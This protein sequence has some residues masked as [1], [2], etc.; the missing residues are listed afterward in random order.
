[1]KFAMVLIAILGM[2]LA[3]LFVFAYAVPQIKS[4]GISEYALYPAPTESEVMGMYVNEAD[5]Y[6]FISTITGVKKFQAKIDSFSKE[7]KLLTLNNET[8][9]A[10]YSSP[11]SHYGSEFESRPIVWGF[12][13]IAPSQPGN[14]EVKLCF[15]VSNWVF[16]R[17]YPQKVI[18][19]V[20]P[21][22]YKLAPE[23]LLTITLNREVYRRGEIMNITIKNVSNE[24]QWFGNAAYDLCFER[25]NGEYWEFYDSIPGVEVITC[26]KPGET[27]QVT[28]KLGGHTDRPFP[29]GQCRVWVHEVHVEFEVI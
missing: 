24:T 15:T 18:V 7:L 6:L 25:F 20:E 4:F 2:T 14:Y 9:V 17:E 19:R 10:P 8:I 3:G 13:I 26:L 5:K 21:M 12:W 23:E 22:P 11:I 27:G 1:M 16:S 28:W 29:A